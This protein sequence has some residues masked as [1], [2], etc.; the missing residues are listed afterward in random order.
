M[1]M[2]QPPRNDLQNL[3]Q[4]VQAQL[5][6]MPTAQLRHVVDGTFGPGTAEGIDE[7]LEGIFGD[8]GKALSSAARD[9]GRFASKAA[10][11]IASI[12]GGVLK[13]AAAGSAL[14]LPG[15]IAGA[16]TGGVGGGLSTYGKAAARQVGQALSGVTQLAGGLTPMGQLGGTL[17]SAVGSLGAP[18]DPA[19]SRGQ[20]GRWG[21]SRGCWARHRREP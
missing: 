4:V 20:R 10:P 21:R 17:G 11:G 7:D 16:A 2:N 15:I 19:G 6:A 14:G 12:G 13:G 18:A 1:L 9:V 3:R 5:A 8:I